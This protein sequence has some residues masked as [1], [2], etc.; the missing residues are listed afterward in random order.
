MKNLTIVTLLVCFT[1]NSYSQNPHVLKDDLSR[2]LVNSNLASNLE[3]CNLIQGEEY[4]YFIYFD[5]GQKPYKI[6]LKSDVKGTGSFF[7]ES[8]CKTF[9]F[10][11]TQTL[12]TG[13]FF[14]FDI[15]K[16]KAKKENQKKQMTFD[17]EPSDDPNALIRNIFQNN[18]CFEIIESS[19][20]FTGNIGSYENGDAIGT[21]DGIIMSTGDVEYAEGPNNST[22][23]LQ[24]FGGAEIDN[25]LSQIVDGDDLFDVSIIEFDFI[26]TGGFV[27]FQY[28]FASEEYCDFVN[29]EFNDAFGFFLSG[30]GINGPFSNNAENLAIVND[31]D[32]VS[33]NTINWRTNQNQYVSNVPP[34]QIQDDNGC[35]NAEI[36]A[37]PVARQEFQYD[38]FTQVLTAFAEVE[39][40]EIYHLKLIIADAVDSGYDSA[41]FLKARSFLAGAD[42]N[43]ATSINGNVDSKVVYENCKDQEFIINIERGEDSVIDEPFLFG[44]DF[45]GSATFDVDY[46]SVELI[47]EIPP[48]QDNL[49]IPITIIS[50]DIAE[51][52]ETIE[53]MLSTTCSCEPTIIEI[54][55][56]DLE[57]LDVAIE[58][59][60]ICEGLQAVIS[61]NVTGGMPDY[62]YSWNNGATESTIEVDPEGQDFFT[63]EV[64]DGCGNQSFDT[65]FLEILDV[66]SAF[67]QGE[68]FICDENQMAEL[69]INI[70]GQGPFELV[71]QNPL[72]LLDTFNTINPSFIIENAIPG[73]YLLI[74]VVGECRGTVE[75]FATVVSNDLMIEF[76][77]EDPD[78]FDDSDGNLNLAING[79]LEPFIIEWED[80]SS[81]LIRENL[82]AGNFLVT[83]T[84]ASGCSQISN[85]TLQNPTLLEA[86][87]SVIGM[88]TCSNPAGGSIDVQVQGG[89]EPY[90][91][92]WNTMDETAS[93]SNLGS[94]IYTLTISDQNGC[95]F[96]IE[97]EIPGDSSIPDV[98]AVPLGVINCN[99]SSTFISADGS[100][101]GSDFI[102]TWTDSDGNILNDNSVVE[103][104]VFSAGF[105]N[106]NV[107]NTNNGCD[108]NIIVE[109]FQDTSQPQGVPLSPSFLSCQN[110]EVDLIVEDISDGSSVVWLDNQ[111]IPL[112]N[113]NGDTAFVSSSGTYRVEI[114]NMDTGCSSI[115]EI[116]VFENI[117]EPIVDA[118]EAFTIDCRQEVFSLSGQTDIDMSIA[119]IAWSS[120]N[121]SFNGETNILNPQIN[122]GGTYILTVR[123]TENG[124]Q[125][126]SEIIIEEALNTP[127]FNLSDPET[128]NCEITEVTIEALNLNPSLEV[129]F[130]WSLDGQIL[131]NENLA[132]IEAGISGVYAVIVTDIVSGCTQVQSIFVDENIQQPMADAGPNV[133]I[134][135]M[136]DQLTLNA[137][138]SQG[139]E[140][141]Y[142]W[143]TSNG[144]INEGATTLNPTISASGEYTL[145]VTNTQ[146]GCTNQSSLMVIPNN[147]APILQA[148]MPDNLTCAN[149][150]VNLDLSVE[151]VDGDFSF[152]WTG[153][154]NFSNNTELNILVNE[155]G[156]YTLTLSNDQNACEST[157]SLE[158]LQNLDEPEFSI[159]L[160]G[161][162]TCSETSV[163]LFFENN[164]SNSNLSFSWSTNNG[165][166]LTDINQ[167][168][169]DVGM[170]GFYSLEVIDM[171]TGCTGIQ[172]IEVFENK[173]V[174]VFSL[175]A[176]NIID[177]NNPL[178][179]VSID[180]DLE[181]TELEAVWQIPLSGNVELIELSENTVSVNQTGTY[182]LILTNLE[183]GCTAEQ[184]VLVTDNF[185]EPEV[186][187]QVIGDINCAN[188]FS[189]LSLQN[190]NAMNLSYQWL[191]EDGI[192]T[193]FTSSQIQVME[194]GLYTAIV[195]N[196]ANGCTIEI[197]LQVEENKKEPIANILGDNLLDCNITSINLIATDI[198]MDNIYAW[199][200][201]NGN[202]I[203]NSTS[204][205][206]TTS[207]TYTLMVSN[208]QSQCFQEDEIV[209]AQAIELPVFEV[210]V[211]GV[212]DCRIEEAIIEVSS[213]DID[214]TYTYT[215]INGN[216]SSIDASFF[217]A[218]EPGVYTITAVNNV[219]GCEQIFEVEVLQDIT[220]PIVDAGPG[221]ELTCAELEYQ[222]QG[223]S[224]LM[225][226][227]T[228]SW[229][230]TDPN[231]FVDG[232]NTFSPT[233]NAPGI[234]EFTIVDE[235]NGCSTTDIVEV[236][237]E[238]NVPREIFTSI[239]DPLCAGDLGSLDIS[240][241]DGGEGP[242]LYSIDNGENYF[243]LGLF[244]DLEPGIYDLRVQDSNGCEIDTQVEIPTVEPVFASLLPEVVLDF[245]E[246]TRLLASTNINPEDIETI[247]WTPSINLSC[248]DCL[249]PQVVGVEDAF[250]TV[251][252]V[253][254]N[255]CVAEVSVQLRVNKEISVY[256]PN[257]FSPI[258]LDGF[259]DVFMIFAKE[260]VVTNINSL[261]VY[262]RWG[263]L[264]FI[265]E[266]FLPN[267]PL[268]AWDG[269]YKD[270]KMNPG[271]FVYWTEIEFIDGR[272]SVFKGNVTLSD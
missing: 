211:P 108:A 225:E 6:E 136:A 14:Y 254:Q 97:E 107:L 259:N 162:L 42:A 128:L 47:Q 148:S 21:S 272:T 22:G 264:V 163:E 62:T 122:S 32:P 60:A 184:I 234:Y 212:L 10:E 214:L 156:I 51:G 104:E 149:S 165:A 191:N 38:G 251:T 81:E 46:S 242:Y 36:N 194:E 121:G 270:E 119:E 117:N 145:I 116:E 174:P 112:P 263:T 172:Q 37:M 94:G 216:I 74:S 206:V 64:V 189:T 87:S 70:E 257:A 200:D 202:I 183:N 180:T 59:S 235:L 68:E 48:N 11:T 215:T 271:V 111:G 20:S 2:I 229:T 85:I 196:E 167:Q 238:E 262:D 231:N 205:D 78:C 247:T 110:L 260:G 40:C 1:I 88:S 252:I 177:C 25:D 143:L 73:E 54:E 159:G 99:I 195:T 118:G 160:L 102:Y 185:E 151:N 120:T 168:N 132:S 245:G 77:S 146:N 90:T 49:Q 155:P 8:T 56:K 52:V 23:N 58:A 150:E 227:I 190:L 267:D 144:I 142:T 240:Q 109:V 157:V 103:I 246:N 199:L 96:I 9:E 198:D 175:S 255:G 164:E 16:R 224:N 269:K 153:P 236:G 192:L 152:E 61:S 226:N 7:A 3:V 41:V 197:P 154:N 166:I 26:P 5:R 223:T 95:T 161:E 30:N 63:L 130:E 186:T 72:G 268:H 265:E 13:D 219:T 86:Q 66:P 131:N 178:A 39:P 233:V 137:I 135:C 55:I 218:D 92:I 43:I 125:S 82:S 239:V 113:I 228:L 76:A 53:I 71:V 27:S 241:I 171:I 29:S 89:I 4:E 84:D 139:L 140:F 45:A 138:A 169:I 220:A 28:V 91:F 208:L 80:G 75:G 193:Q 101:V 170:P 141:E 24:G 256:I 57:V 181:F 173:E 79:G 209:I 158:V 201:E 187:G 15:K 18:R 93:L 69:V 98:M 217:I 35:R 19:I 207:G 33:V 105:Y 31:T 50:D 134:T 176:D 44:L 182:A 126:Q 115:F 203:S 250:Y 244:E 210:A 222:L 249:D 230:A 133:S 213:D 100:S 12:K 67:L 124:C 114:I 17:V 123:N 261:Q 243:D 129:S 248:S 106:L 232:Q 253:S 221:F 204:L 147:D 266:N 188:E 179:F 65:V 258:N 237:L 34:N 127:N 83:V